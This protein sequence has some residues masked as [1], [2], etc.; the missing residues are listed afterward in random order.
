MK[1]GE[2]KLTLVQTR[3]RMKRKIHLASITQEQR[4]QDIYAKNYPHTVVTKHQ[5]Q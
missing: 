5:I 1:F 4:N 3:E 2:E